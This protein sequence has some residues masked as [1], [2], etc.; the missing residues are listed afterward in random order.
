MTRC[1]LEVWNPFNLFGAQKPYF[2]Y[3][4]MIA[5]DVYSLLL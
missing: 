1:V 2:M 4:E 5:L 3:L